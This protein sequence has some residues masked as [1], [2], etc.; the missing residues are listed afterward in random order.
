MR[1][2]QPSI[3]FAFTMLI[4]LARLL[5][6]SGMP[7]AQDLSLAVVLHAL[8]LHGMTFALA[9]L[10]VA[11]MSRATATRAAQVGL[12]AQGVLF[13]APFVDVGLGLSVS[14][15]DATYPGI[16]GT[17]GAIVASIAYASV[18]AWGVWDA[19]LGAAR[20]RESIASLSGF[21]AFLGLSVAAL[22]WP[23]AFLEP[24][25]WGV[26]LVLAA[27]FGLL[28][29][30]F[31]HASIHFAN[32]PLHREM[33]REVQLLANLGFALLPL[34]GVMAAGRLGLPPSPAEPIQRFRIEAPFMMG[35]V[36]VA[37]VLFVEWRL[38][39]SR[40]WAPFQREAAAIAKG[41]A[42][43]GAL[44]LGIGPFLV[45]GLAGSLLWLSRSRWNP[46]VFGIVG[47]LAVLVGDLTVVPIDFAAVTAGPVTFFVPINQ[48]AL[49]SPAGLSIAAAV[50]FVVAL[51]SW[52]TSRTSAS[53][54]DRASS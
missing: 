51:G 5:A 24:L 25:P 40:A 38:V 15:Y 53:G 14:S 12:Y 35:A 54:R 23:G 48:V 13:L 4:G 16:F 3:L 29:A 6:Y 19:S 42:I 49:P 31:G 17:P 20:M 28:A 45:A 46:A 36:A 9:A 33:W 27:Y 7:L 26:H 43:A 41:A 30:I 39:R 8:A 34:L 50:A 1:R 52:L 10:V 22:P 37:A 47:G 11:A 18:V 32:R 2:G 44:L 21:L